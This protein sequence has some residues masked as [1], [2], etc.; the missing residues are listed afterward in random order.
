MALFYTGQ[1]TGLGRRFPRV[2]LLVVF[3]RPN[4]VLLLRTCQLSSFDIMSTLNLGYSE[5]VTSNKDAADLSP[6]LV[7]ASTP[8]WLAI[9]YQKRKKLEH[10]FRKKQTEMWC[11]GNGLSPG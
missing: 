9:S 8:Y 2:G 6:Q 4:P 5:N 7:V 10:K 1:D 11:R 3:Y